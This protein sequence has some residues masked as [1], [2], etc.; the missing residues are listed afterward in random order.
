[1]P[2]GLALRRTPPVLEIEFDRP[3]KHN[4]INLAMWRALPGLV[5]HAVD[6]D[7]LAVIVLCG[8]GGDFSAG[9]DIGEFAEVRSTP[10][11]RTAYSAAVDAAERAL[12]GCPMPVIARVSGYC[13]GGGLELALACDYRIAG[14]STR[15]AIPAAKVGIVYS[16]Q[17]TRRLVAAVGA[18]FAKFVMY[19]GETFPAEVGLAKGLFDELCPDSA[20]GEVTARVAAAMA[21]GSPQTIAAAK[22]VIESTI[23]GVSADDALLEKLAGE[24]AA[25]SAYRDAVERFRR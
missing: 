10:E 18:G 7:E 8:A 9:A 19:T 1:M 4:A 13:L 3:A 21:K 22:L 20:L 16:A 24:G 2:E 15:A 11:Q 5:Q 14:E 23:T 17:S 25:G 6:D 12:S